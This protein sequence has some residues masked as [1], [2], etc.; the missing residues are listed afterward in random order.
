MFAL[1]V[2]DELGYQLTAPRYATVSCQYGYRLRRMVSRQETAD[3]LILNYREQDV[4]TTT[5][6]PNCSGTPGTAYSAVRTGRWAFSLRTG[7]S[8]QWPFMGLLAGEYRQTPG[9]TVWLT[10]RGYDLYLETGNCLLEGVPL[11]FVG[12]YGTGSTGPYSPGIDYLALNQYFTTTLGVGPSYFTDYYEN[13]LAY[14]R[15]GNATCGQPSYF[16]GLLPSRTAAA[17]AAAT[18][19]PNPTAEA[20]TLTL[21]TP[22]P[23]GTVLTLLD[24]TGRR[25]WARNVAP[26]QTSL[27]I[28]L[29]GQ[30]AGLYLVQLLAPGTTPLTW[31]LTHEL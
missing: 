10:G 6:A 1:G 4:I 17:A 21:A 9:N 30:P 13:N 20:A 5:N 19:H 15:R 29:P 18:L 2:G 31:K 11:G 26:G 12:V 23:P 14:Y 22:T 25:I 8:P 28:A 16:A 24:G 3:S 27:P 7:A